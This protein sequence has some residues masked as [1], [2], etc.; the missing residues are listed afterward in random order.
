MSNTSI[1]PV[2]LAPQTPPPIETPRPSVPPTAAIPAPLAPTPPTVSAPPAAAVPP[3]A[4]PPSSAAPEVTSWQVEAHVCKADD[5]ILKVCQDKYHDPSYEKALLAYNRNYQPGGSGIHNDPPTLQPGQVL[6]LPP[7]AILEKKYHD[8]IPN[9]KPVA[10][11][12]APT[13]PALTTSQSSP[14][15][16][17]LYTVQANGET[18]WNIAQQMLGNGERWAEISQLNPGLDVSRPLAG[19]TVLRLP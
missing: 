6:L 3:I 16:A 19:G 2:A 14:G 15:S 8:L 7:L 17:R 18:I 13:A 9:L 11:P 12:S 1:G 5:S 10:V 4:V